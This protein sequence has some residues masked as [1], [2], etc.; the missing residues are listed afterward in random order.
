MLAAAPCFVAL[1][2]L[3]QGKVREKHI[4]LPATTP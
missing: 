3:S 4:V 1:E 2:P